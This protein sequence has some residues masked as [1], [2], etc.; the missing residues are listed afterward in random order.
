M[1][2]VIVPALIL[3]ASSTLHTYI[4]NL[5]I[6]RIQYTIPIRIVTGEIPHGAVRMTSNS[7]KYNV[8]ESTRRSSS[9]EE[10]AD[11]KGRT[12]THQKITLPIFEKQTIQE[13][14]LRWR[15][16]IQYAKKTQYIDLNTMTTE[17]EVI[18][19]HRDELE[20]KIKDVSIWAPGEA[21]VTEMTK[22]VT[23][24]DPNKTNRNQ[25]FSL[26]NQTEQLKTSGHKSY[27]QR[28]TVISTTLPR[29]N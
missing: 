4:V 19:E 14:K 10:S 3:L 18:A 11:K 16:F 23:D 22:T 20:I 15:R 28:K 1:F 2:E 5:I 9:S 8:A 13:A 24:K 29:Q 26:E 17:K 7:E 21:A 25:L 6:A 27:K 12:K